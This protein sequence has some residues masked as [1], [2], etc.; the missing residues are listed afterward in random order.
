M[1]YKLKSFVIFHNDNN[2]DNNNPLHERGF[3]GIMKQTQ[4]EH[5]M[6]KDSSWQEAHQLV[7]LQAAKELRKQLQIVVRMGLE[8][9][10]L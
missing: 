7:I 2:N 9:S 1:S 4:I 10:T 3:S 6:V 8:S 5:I